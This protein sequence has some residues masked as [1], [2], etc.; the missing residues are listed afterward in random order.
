M[1]GGITNFF[2]TAANKEINQSMIY[3]GMFA[4]GITDIARASKKA[5]KTADAFQKIANATGEMKDNV[6]AFDLERLTILDNLF[7]NLQQLS[8]IDGGI[9]ELSDQLR[10]T[11]SDSFDKL[12]EY[13][14]ELNDTTA[15]S[16]NSIT[17]TLQKLNP[18]SQE[19][20]TKGE[21]VIKMDPAFAQ[22][23]ASL[24][25]ALASGIPVEVTNI[26]DL[27]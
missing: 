18:F 21:Q 4:N 13:M 23:I 17:S 11:I 16:G 2:T 1:F 7:Y 15:A 6:N 26:N 12:A 8:K 24:R 10:D 9:S 19:T 20:N 14:S 3:M 22:Q 27:S 25:T 5:D